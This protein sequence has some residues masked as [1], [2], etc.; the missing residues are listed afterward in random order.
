[1]TLERGTRARL[2]T[3]IV[4][5]LVLGAGVI[6]GVALD[7]QLEARGVIGAQE[8][9]PGGRLGED[10]R[11]RGFDPRSRDPSR[12][13]REGRDSTHRRPSL[14]V[15]QVG[16]SEEQR[17]QADSIYWL[18]RSRMRDL[19]EEFDTAYNS[20]F[21]EIMAQSREDMLSILTTEQRVVYDSLL[22][23]WEGRREERRRDTVP[24]PGGNGDGR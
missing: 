23:D 12:G 24:E 8:R 15:E 11:R 21:E 19:H 7:R 10:S 9:R 14:I 17:A 3:A 20:R 1:M 16:L 4:L 18:Y 22:S 6:L 13:P 5:F 2:T